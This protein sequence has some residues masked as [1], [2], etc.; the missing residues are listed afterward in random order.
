MKRERERGRDG[1]GGVGRSE[2]ERSC[3]VMGL[4]L[5]HLTLRNCKSS[6]RGVSQVDH[7]TV[8]LRFHATLWNKSLSEKR[9]F[10]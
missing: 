5:E 4:A 8:T 7:F 1:G 2:G 9:P 10:A 6:K 3:Q